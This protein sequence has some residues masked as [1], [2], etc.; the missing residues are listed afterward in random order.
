FSEPVDTRAVPTYLAVISHPMDFG[1]MREKVK[2][3]VYKSLAQFEADFWLVIGNCKK[4]NE[5]GSIYWREA[6]KI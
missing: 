2:A 1:T 4:F 3:K 5:A 6:D